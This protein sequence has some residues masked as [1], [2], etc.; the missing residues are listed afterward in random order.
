MAEVQM[1][2]G[3]LFGLASGYW[4]PC[5]LHAGVKLGVFTALA[6][7]AMSAAE[8]AGQLQASERGL[9]LL[10]N[11]LTA[12]DLLEK[13]DSLFR[14]TPLAANYLDRNQPDYVGHIIMHHHF[15]VE[16]W[17]RLDEAV[18]SGRP[19][20]TEAEDEELERESFQMGMFN[21][22]RA[23]APTISASIDL[24]D[25]RSL[26]DLGGG[27]G[28]HAVFFCLANPGLTATVFDRPTTRPFAEKIAKRYGVSDRI[29]FVPGDFHRDPIPGR[30]DVAWLSQI[31]HS[32]TAD[33]CRGLIEK[34]SAV[35]EPGGLLLIHEFFLEEN[36]AAPL[37][38]ALFSLNMLVNNY[39]RSYAAQETEEMMR[40]AGFTDIELLPF[41]GGNDS[42]ILAGVKL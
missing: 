28:T 35:L 10:L 6:D 24:S 31:L 40:E 27:P 15:L 2:P 39:G 30:F 16:S 20:E 8:L 14:N 34:T 29:D 12:M 41:R 3:K 21:L 22:A 7:G 42:S 26:L 25:R 18:K 37:F 1:H 5:T 4:Q 19:V 17:S 38:P 11:G 9:E 32:N 33:E 13:D 36:R 23:I